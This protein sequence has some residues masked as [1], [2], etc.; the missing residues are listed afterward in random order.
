MNAFLRRCFGLGLK[1]LHQRWIIEVRDRHE[2]DRDLRT[3]GQMIGKPNAAHAPF[4][5]E[6]DK[7]QRRRDQLTNLHASVLIS[8]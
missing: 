6:A 2:L 7:F 3:E 4:T 8:R 1:T 5:Q